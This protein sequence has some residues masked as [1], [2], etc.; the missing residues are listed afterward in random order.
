MPLCLMEVTY[1]YNCHCADWLNE[2]NDH[3]SPRLMS[4]HPL[5]GAWL[6]QHRGRIASVLES[7]RKVFDRSWLLVLLDWFTFLAHPVVVLQNNS[8]LLQI[9]EDVPALDT[10]LRRSLDM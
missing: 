4:L 10:D 7:T 3:S 5:A 8:D 1:S 2:V 9:D 6:V